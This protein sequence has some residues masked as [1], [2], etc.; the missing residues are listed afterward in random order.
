MQVPGSVKEM[1]LRLG[2]ELNSLGFAQAQRLSPLASSRAGIYLAGAFHEPK[3]IPDSVAQGSAA[4]ACAMSQLTSVR[5]TL[6]QRREYPWERDVADESPRIGVFVCHCGHNVSSVVD[7]EQVARKAA[8]LPHVCHAE[9]TVYTCSDSNQRHIRDMI[10]THRLNRLVVASCSSRTH[11]VLFR[12]TLRESGLNQFLFAMTNI[13]DQCAWV[14]K[15]DPSAATAKASD[16]VS[17]TVARARFMKALPLKELPVTASAM[18]LGGGLAG[19]TAAHNLA[20]QGFLV[21]LVERAPVLG[22]MARNIRITLEGTDVGA[23]LDQLIHATASHPRIK[24]F[25]K[26]DLVRISGQP[27]DFTSVLNVNGSETRV[28]HGVVILAT[29]GQERSTEQYFHG[30]RGDVI[31]Q[32]KL[33]SMLSGGPPHPALSGKSDPTIAMIQCVESRDAKNPY[34][35]RVCCSEAV[36]NALEIKR[37]LPHSRVLILGRDMRTYG[38]REIYYQKALEQGVEFI[39]HPDD[40]LEVVEN[41]GRLEVEVY[42]VAAGRGRTILPDLLVLS[43]GIAPAE[44]NSA[45]SGVLRSALTDDGF[46]QEAHPKLRPVELANEG[47]FLCGVAHSPRFM[48]ETIIQAH[49]AAARA[50]AILSKAQ[51]E[52][53]GHMACVNPAECVACATCVRLCPYGAPVI[54]DLRKAEVRGAMCMGCG[55]C[56]AAC[57]SRAVV[58]QQQER[59]PFSAM[60]DE[61]LVSGGSR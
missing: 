11:E 35:S 31:T 49:A 5:G 27:G 20:A 41:E 52:I 18:I 59:E 6:M 45:L 19:M 57:P 37:R 9:A 16:L 15:D 7:V 17:M 43:T 60:L 38:F 25:L 54:N 29:G 42:D 56:V 40:A 61:L 51:L 26:S 21:Y 47:E 48:D 22:G 58:L 23:H 33:E 13:R 39:R 8:R 2:V 3:D 34:C 55:S 24:V 10:R 46:F 50:S 44:T 12:E 30:R 53:V 4:A 28:E 14:H 32:S 1:A 36:K